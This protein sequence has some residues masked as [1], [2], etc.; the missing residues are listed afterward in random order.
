MRGCRAILPAASRVLV[1]SNVSAKLVQTGHHWRLP[2]PCLL[3]PLRHRLE[4]WL[5]WSG[6]T[7][8]PPKDLPSFSKAPSKCFNIFQSSF[9]I[10]TETLF[11]QLKSRDMKIILLQLGISCTPK[12]ECEKCESD[13]V[14]YVDALMH[15]TFNWWRSVN[16][17][18]AFATWPRL[19]KEKCQVQKQ[20]LQHVT[21]FSDKARLTN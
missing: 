18:A 10:S 13:M 4:G 19:A 9:H 6:S 15:R 17:Q 20:K 1:P 7:W 21:T 5:G 11:H 16:P 14:W 8:S 3:R 2:G 12:P